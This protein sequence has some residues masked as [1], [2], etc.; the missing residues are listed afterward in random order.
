MGEVGCRFDYLQA[1]RLQVPD[2]A[3]E[4]EEFNGTK[5]IFIAQSIRKLLMRTLQS[6]NYV[7]NST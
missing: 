5:I 6:T 4:R 3:A 7:A 1:W 2:I